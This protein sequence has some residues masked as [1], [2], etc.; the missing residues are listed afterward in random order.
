MPSKG[1]NMRR[2]RQ[3]VV[4]TSLSVTAATAAVL[5]PAAPA[6]AIVGDTPGYVANFG[7]VL[8]FFD[9]GYET[10]GGTQ[11]SP[12]W[13]LTAGHCI[14]DVPSPYTSILVDGWT[15]DQVIAHPLWD[16]DSSHGHDLA[17][18]HLPAGAR[19]G[20]ASIPQVGAPWNPAA[21]A[22]GTQAEIMG[23][24]KTSA[25]AAPVDGPSPLLTANTVSLFTSSGGG[26]TG[27]GGGRTPPHPL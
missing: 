2:L 21:Y 6:P 22:P 1:D 24:G 27:G 18:L 13:I 3:M 26:G 9:Q 25:H 19:P 17:L 7:A 4:A 15:V 20:G 12:S 23:V 8:V 16:G 11:I 14:T 10:C 5:V